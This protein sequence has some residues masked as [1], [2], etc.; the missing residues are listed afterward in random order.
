MKKGIGSPEMLANLIWHKLGQGRQNKDVMKTFRQYF[1]LVVLILFSTIFLS[2][3]LLNS[4]DSQKAQELQQEASQLADDYEFS[5]AMEKY[6]Q[7]LRLDMRNSNIYVGIAE[8]YLLK[9]RQDDALEVLEKGIANAPS[10]NLYTL[11]GK[12]RLQKKD[13]DGAVKDLERGVGM[14]NKNSEA[15][16]FLALALTNKKDFSKARKHIVLSQ[17]E[18]ETLRA[19]A[20]LLQAVILRDQVEQSR[21]VLDQISKEGLKEESVLSNINAYLDVLDYLEEIPENEMSNKYRDVILAKGAIEVGI[22]DVAIELLQKYA[23]LEGEYWEVYL[24]LGQAYLLEENLEKAEEFL[25]MAVSLN[26]GNYLSPWM[27]GRVY[28]KNN[29]IEKSKENYLRSLE[30]AD[31]SQKIL[32]REEFAKV[33][34]EEEQFSLADEQ[35]QKLIEENP[36]GQGVYLLSRVGIAYERG[37]VSEINELLTQ[38]NTSQLADEKLAN[39][40]YYKAV[41]SL[42]ENELEDAKKW[43]KD[44]IELDNK[45]STYYLLYGQ[46]LFE[47]GNDEEAKKHFQQS[48]DLDLSGEDSA[49]AVKFLDRI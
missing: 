41:V 48:V 13:F 39:Y 29:D 32:I 3:C 22:E 21:E 18:D 6:E 14:N 34:H 42:E 31:K 27:L 10:S 5:S 37:L 15:R 30:L 20:A 2:G 35:Y 23:E 12:V 46:I 44:S 47:Q 38:I 49:K 28:Y 24:Y 1:V 40:Y 16:Y 26:P 8:I 19:K 11:R 43:I 9:N 7:A 4:E 25:N 33:L 45:S 17:M 36:Q